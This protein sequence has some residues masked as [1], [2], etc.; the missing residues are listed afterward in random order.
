MK[1]FK[2]IQEIDMYERSMENFIAYFFDV[3]NE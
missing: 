3:Q 2:L 1:N